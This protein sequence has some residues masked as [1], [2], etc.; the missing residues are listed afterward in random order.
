MSSSYRSFSSYSVKL[1]RNCIPS[2]D[3]FSNYSHQSGTMQYNLWPID[4]I[5]TICIE[6]FGITAHTEHESKW[7]I[8]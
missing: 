1:V 3:I 6:T 5:D 8:I 7:V 4:C 2:L